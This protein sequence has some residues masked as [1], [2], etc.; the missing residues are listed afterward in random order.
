MALQIFIEPKHN[1]KYLGAILFFLHWPYV[2]VS[3]KPH[4]S[5]FAVGGVV[6]VRL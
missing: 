1:I 4:P 6:C 5:T 2:A 3:N